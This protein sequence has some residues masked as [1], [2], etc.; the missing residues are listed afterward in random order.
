[1]T[2]SS[3]CAQPAIDTPHSPATVASKLAEASPPVPMATPTP[4]ITGDAAALLNASTCSRP[5]VICGPSGVGKG[6]LL[7]KLFAEFPSVF[8]FSISHTTRGPRPGEENGRD[9]HFTNV[10]AFAQD[11]A[12][13]KFIETAT[14]SGN[15]YG[16][17]F[18]SVRNVISAGKSCILEI[19][20]QGAISVSKTD[21]NAV[22]I[23]ISPPSYA[24]LHSR[25]T[26]RGT[27]TSDQLAARLQAANT[28]LEFACGSDLFKHIVVNDDLEVAFQKLVTVLAS[29]LQQQ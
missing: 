19:D 8:G 15:R 24:E 18:E 25:L 10:D 20:I 1:M 4:E 22:F 14:F 2:T 21:M 11:L 17:S 29:E 5:V 3:V 28:E 27:E 12:E 13:G 23:F 9:Y 6:T 16:T 7:K 26:G